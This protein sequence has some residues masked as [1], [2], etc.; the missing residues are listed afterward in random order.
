MDH[1]QINGLK[2]PR[3]FRSKAERKRALKEAGFVE[4]NCH[5]PRY[6]SDKGLDTTNWA[7]Q[8]DPY[9]AANVKELLERAF[10]QTP[11]PAVKP[12]NI[13]WHEDESQ[14]WE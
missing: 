8:Y 10:Q 3:R 9:T 11:E 13:R 1:L 4:A 12:L 7:A 5:V 6:G 14:P 2:E